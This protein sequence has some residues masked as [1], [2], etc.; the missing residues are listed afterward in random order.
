MGLGLRRGI[1]LSGL[2]DRDDPELVPLALAE[3]WH[4]SLKVVDGGAAV[5]VVGDQGVKPTL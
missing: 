3:A 5:V 4:P 1:R 2:V